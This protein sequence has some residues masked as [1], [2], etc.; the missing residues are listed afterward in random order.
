MKDRNDYGF[1]SSGYIFDRLHRSALHA[2]KKEFDFWKKDI[3]TSWSEIYFDFP[4]SDLGNVRVFTESVSKINTDSYEVK[5][6]LRKHSRR[7][8]D[9]TFWFKITKPTTKGEE[10]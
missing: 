3:R 9:A 5:N 10:E 8:A 4:L 2:I 1:Y 7:V 6:T